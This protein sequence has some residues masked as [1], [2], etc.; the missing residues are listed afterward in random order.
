[1]GRRTVFYALRAAGKTVRIYFDTLSATSNRQAP[2]PGL[3]VVPS[4]AQRANHPLA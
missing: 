3:A 2:G 4:S 1:M